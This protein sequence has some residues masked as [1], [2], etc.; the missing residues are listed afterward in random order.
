MVPLFVYL[1]KLSFGLG[2]F[3]LFYWL[4][5]K[6]EKNFRFNRFYLLSALALSAIMPL[7]RFSD[8]PVTF[9]AE[10]TVN[11]F[12][13]NGEA[14]AG[15]GL[16]NSGSA[17]DPFRIPLSKPTDYAYPIRDNHAVSGS[18]VSDQPVQWN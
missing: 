9:L 3:L 7:I 8:T 6:K 15:G 1:I 13:T 10:K 4:L 14:I 11:L 16:S 18:L 5:I 2:L 17:D 12:Q